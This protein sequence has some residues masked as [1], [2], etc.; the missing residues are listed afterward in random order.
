MKR[1]FKGV[2]SLTLS[3][4]LIMTFTLTALA[5]YVEPEN[6]F[7]YGFE[8]GYILGIPAG[9]TKT[10][11]R[12]ELFKQPE[13]N[14]IT[15][16][17]ANNE[18]IS[19][20]T[21]I[22]TNFIVTI[23]TYDNSSSS[24][25]NTFRTVIYGD[26]NGDGN[27]TTAD[28]SIL[29]NYIVGNTTLSNAAARAA[30]INADIVVDILDKMLIISKA[31]NA[32]DMG[33][34][35]LLSITDNRPGHTH[36]EGLNV[37]ST[38]AMFENVEYDVNIYQDMGKTATINLLKNSSVFACRCHGYIEGIIVGQDNVY[39]TIK[40]I[41]DLDSNAFS[42]NRLIYYGAC[43]V[44]LL[45]S[46]HEE[47][48]VNVTYSKGPTTVI[49]FEQAVD[50][51]PATAWTQQFFKSLGYGTT[52]YD[53]LLQADYVVKY[54]N[55]E[56]CLTEKRTTKGP[57]SQMLTQEEDRFF[58]KYRYSDQLASVSTA[59]NYSLNSGEKNVKEIVET[60][61]D[62]FFGYM[63][64]R[65]SSATASV[66]TQK[67]E[68]TIKSIAI[69]EL[70]QYIDV[71]KYNLYEFKYVEDTNAY[72][73][74][75]NKI[76][77]GIATDDIAFMMIDINGNILA[78]GCKNI[79]AFDDFDFSKI[80]TSKLPQNIV[81]QTGISTINESD[82]ISTFLAFDE[83]DNY[84]LRTTVK[85]NENTETVDIAIE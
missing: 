23:S 14:S 81:S 75:Y 9:T 74:T 20:S 82:V 27:I 4:I 8:S 73:I 30:D 61:D 50:C 54:G 29:N 79:G 46:F 85:V 36:L 10:E 59:S 66:V 44:G 24:I 11:L 1:L 62:R 78:L 55:Y 72:Y 84:V 53:A 40:D 16:K 37:S 31:N 67:S 15:I 51:P 43:E 68:E 7:H 32:N 13:V 18:T 57:R 41:A 34:M 26:V 60:N 42:G 39:L 71:S 19:G 70:S 5:S 35:A 77:N 52:I 12:N 47:N 80:S 64:T 76:I 65:V 48:L 58:A 17:N 38:N 22:G 25:T 33:E 69:K 2:F 28:S 49:G 3:L 45:G 56:N 63:G 21:L 83:N 6:Y